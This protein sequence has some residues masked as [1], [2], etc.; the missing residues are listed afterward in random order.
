MKLTL[1]THHH[2]VLDCSIISAGLSFI[3]LTHPG[4]F[5]LILKRGI[6]LEQSHFFTYYSQVICIYAWPDKMNLKV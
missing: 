1:N 6:M 5:Y 3:Q 4:L 2:D